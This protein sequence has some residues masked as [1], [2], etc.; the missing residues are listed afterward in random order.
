MCMMEG[1]E[2]KVIAKGLCAKHYM[3][4]RR[5]GDAS[6]TRKRG[7]RPSPWL[8]YLRDL[9][10]EYSPR[11]RARY[12][13]AMSWLSPHGQEAMK[14]AI[15]AATRPNGTV[16]V[17]RLIEIAAYKRAGFEKEQDSSSRSSAGDSGFVST[18]CQR[19]GKLAS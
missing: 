8:E 17:T 10:P 1:C 5:T 12:A 6:Q 19:C 7:P 9:L 11:T 16:N 18:V 13:Q 2:G 15:D 3:R 14:S 4:Q